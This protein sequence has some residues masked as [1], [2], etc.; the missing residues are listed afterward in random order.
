MNRF[1]PDGDMIVKK[2]MHTIKVMVKATN[3]EET[4]N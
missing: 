4:I 2:Q 1:M 3:K